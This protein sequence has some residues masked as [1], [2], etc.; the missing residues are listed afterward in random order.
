MLCISIEIP[1]KDSEKAIS[2]N[3]NFISKIRKSEIKAVAFATSENEIKMVFIFIDIGSRFI[4]PQIAEKNETKKIK[5]TDALA[6]L[7]KEFVKE[8]SLFMCS[9][10]VLLLVFLIPITTPQIS[11]D[12]RQTIYKVIP[13]L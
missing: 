12:K 5:L 8:Y 10:L 11:E 13:K 1:E 9:A 3:L 2:D 6:Q 7:F 4:M